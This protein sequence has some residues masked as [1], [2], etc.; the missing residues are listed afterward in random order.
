MS[1]GTTNTNVLVTGGAGF[2]GSHLVDALLLK[3]HI[4]TVLDDLSSG[5]QINL[6]QVCRLVIG[7][8]RDPACVDWCMQGQDVVFHLAAFT[9]VPG[10]IEQPELCDGINILGSQTVLDSAL[11]AGIKR[12]V[13]ASTS[14]VYADYPDIPRS[15][16][17]QP[18]PQSPYAKSKLEVEQILETSLR[19]HGLSYTAMRFFNVYGPRQ[20]ADSDYASVIPKFIASRKAKGTL[21]IFGD[22]SQTRD[23]VYVADVVEALVTAMESR[24]NGIF[25]VGTAQAVSV[26]RLAEKLLELEGTDSSYNFAD[27]RP[28]DAVSSTADI[29]NTSSLLGWSHKWTLANGLAE[30]IK[31]FDE[32]MRG[33]KV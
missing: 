26:L 1:T 8:I 28:G 22:G 16:S 23:F 30:T 2:I 20:E 10:S 6:P 14:A 15:E 3:G 31:W 18:D 33:S 7:D 19:Q 12:F 24:E 13:F 11:T 27:P 29:S 21:T 17:S 5:K 4:V 9:S 32:Y 25:N